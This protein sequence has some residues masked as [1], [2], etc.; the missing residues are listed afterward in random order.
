MP[1]TSYIKIFG[2]PVLEAIKALEQISVDIPE[3]CI[4]D[5]VIANE[6]PRNLARDVGGWFDSRG[7]TIPIER[8]NSIISKSGQKLGD[9]DFFFEWFSNPS[10]DQL[11]DLIE[12]IDDILDPL[13]CRYT[14]STKRTRRG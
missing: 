4:T 9:Y 10:M 7:V 5:F 14:I 1:T 8:C 6:I 2:P 3:V 12:K 13:G 11:S